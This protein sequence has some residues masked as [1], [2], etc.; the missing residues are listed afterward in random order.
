[1]R[2]IICI[3]GGAAVVFG[4]FFVT[5]W[6]TEPKVAVTPKSAADNHSPAE[7]LAAQ[8]ISSYLDLSNAARNAGLHVSREMRGVID[9]ISRVNEREVSIEGWLADPGGGSTPL[10]VLV[11]IGGPMLATAR[12]KGK[13]PDVTNAL[14]L[15]FG[16]EENVAF[17]VNFK[18]KLGEEPVVVGLG[19]RNQY[20]PIQSQNVREVGTGAFPEE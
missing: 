4:S 3:I 5:L 10:N 7:R 18:C 1:M 12:T 15:G 8:S 14:R 20:I 11:F 19:E 17:S 16:T 6:L 9:A 13:R 2:R